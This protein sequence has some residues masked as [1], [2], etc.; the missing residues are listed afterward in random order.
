M[1]ST[2]EKL[3]QSTSLPVQGHGVAVTEQIH[4]KGFSSTLQPPQNRNPWRGAP[5]GKSRMGSTL[6]ARPLPPPMDPE[7]SEEY[8]GAVSW[9][10]RRAPP[11]QPDGEPEPEAPI[12]ATTTTS[13]D[14]LDK[15]K[16]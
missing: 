5:P 1:R 10:Y 13:Q 7:D 9:S 14:T 11:I 6:P 8:V 15:G 4:T 2:L 3:L 12:A 16:G